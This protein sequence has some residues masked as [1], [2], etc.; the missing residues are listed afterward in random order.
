MRWVFWSLTSSRFRF[1]MVIATVWRPTRWT[2]NKWFWN[3]NSNFTKTTKIKYCF[4]NHLESHFLI[5]ND[6]RVKTLPN[7]SCLPRYTCGDI[8][9]GIDCNI[10]LIVTCVGQGTCAQF[11]KFGWCL[12][13]WCVLFWSFLFCFFLHSYTLT[14]LICTNAHVSCTRA[15][16]T[17][18]LSPPDPCG[19]V[20]QGSMVRSVQIKILSLRENVEP[21]VFDPTH[22]HAMEDTQ[23]RENCANKIGWIILIQRNIGPWTWICTRFDAITM[24][25][26]FQYI[27]WV[28]YAAIDP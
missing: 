20:T 25:F 3:N 2:Y 8:L 11:R 22:P 27:S 13:D 6:D 21:L 24:K 14:R 5:S 4:S 23:V 12:N 15:S 16:V 18:F 1:E 7:C 17:S 19:H 10:G 26:W 28:T 9:N